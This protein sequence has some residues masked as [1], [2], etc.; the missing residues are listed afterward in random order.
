[1]VDE[2]EVPMF[3]APQGLPHSC[4]KVRVRGE[5]TT[6]IQDEYVVSAEKLLNQDDLWRVLELDLK[7]RALIEKRKFSRRL[8]N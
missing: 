7:F 5:S 8:T 4:E 2:V 1:V 6:R 3:S